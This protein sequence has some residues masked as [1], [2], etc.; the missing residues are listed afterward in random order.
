MEIHAVANQD[1]GG[2][3]T[4]RPRKKYRQVVAGEAITAGQVVTFY[5]SGSTMDGVRVYV[6]TAA[7]DFV[8]GV[9]L[10]T[11]GAAG[12]PI[13][14]QCAGLG[15]SALT[16]DESAEAGLALVAAASGVVSGQAI[17]ASTDNCLFGYVLANDDSTTLAA[18]NY[19]L[20][21]WW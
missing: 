16:T 20:K 8:C 17:D 14:I 3:T 11:A 13:K 9:A 15:E 10:E 12:V 2:Q 1:L 6:T 7:T 19:V 21:C 4:A 18:G 5:K